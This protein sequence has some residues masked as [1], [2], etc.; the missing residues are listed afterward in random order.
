M[1]PTVKVLYITIFGLSLL[2]LTI[3]STLYIAEKYREKHFRD[4]IIFWFFIIIYFIAQ[5]WPTQ[6]EFFIALNFGIAVVPVILITKLSIES[7]RKKPQILRYI[8]FYFF[9]L[10]LTVISERLGLGFIAMSLPIA[11]AYIIPLFEAFYISNIKERKNTTSLQ[12]VIGYILLVWCANCLTFVFFRLDESNLYWGWSITYVFFNAVSIF[13]PALSLESS[14]RQETTRLNE[15][16][17]LKTAAL[18]QLVQKHQNLLRIIIHDL[19]NPLFVNKIYVSDILKKYP[20]Y[21]NAN[22]LLRSHTAIESILKKVRD[23]HT[24]AEYGEKNYTLVK[25]AIQ[26]LAN[27]FEDKLSTKNI[28]LNISDSV[29]T[30]DERIVFDSTLFVHSVLGNILQNAIKFSQDN[31]S[32]EI[33]SQTN[34]KSLKIS[35]TDHGPGLSQEVLNLFKKNH[36]QIP[37]LGTKGEKGLGLGLVIVKDLV[38]SNGGHISAVSHLQTEGNTNHGTSFII[39]LPLVSRN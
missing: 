8:L 21:P 18:D 31:S 25:D 20:E 16:V 7:A 5:F 11:I 32:I 3:L 39:E 37:S 14:K 34:G 6:N 4:I 2:N 19:N 24:N 15:Q 33:T 28:T 17:A 27:N 22:K 12:K 10:F 13:L 30:G 26:E 9:A 35:I 23:E 29:T 1:N 36:P 38:E